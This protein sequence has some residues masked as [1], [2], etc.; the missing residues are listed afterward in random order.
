MY[1]FLFRGLSGLF[2]DAPPRRSD[3]AKERSL[4][5][6]LTRCPSS[7]RLGLAPARIAEPADSP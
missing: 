2:R 1:E 5:Q 3:S 6:S 4:P 7:E